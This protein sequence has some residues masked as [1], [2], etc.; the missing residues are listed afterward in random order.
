MIP[1]FC[2]HLITWRLHLTSLVKPCPGYPSQAL[3]SDRILSQKWPFF[4]QIVSTY[5]DLPSK[6]TFNLTP[7]CSLTC[8]VDFF[9][10]KFSNETTSYVK[11]AFIFW[12]ETVFSKHL[13]VNM[14]PYLKIQFQSNYFFLKVMWW[15]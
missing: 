7:F 14:K 11:C 9:I 3:Y 6:L 10:F 2:L 8:H 5:Y 4:N 13:L 15:W 1:C 12:T